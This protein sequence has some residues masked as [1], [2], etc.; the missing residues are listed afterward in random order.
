MVQSRGTVERRVAQPPRGSNK[1]FSDMGCV[2][3][4][5]GWQAMGRSCLQ[6]D[7]P[8][9]HEYLRGGQDCANLGRVPF[10]TGP[11]WTDHQIPAWLCG[12]WHSLLQWAC[13]L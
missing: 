3:R 10:A 2:R 6:C 11:A 5:W 7:L 12:D 9:A 4:F 13:S 8:G 1:A